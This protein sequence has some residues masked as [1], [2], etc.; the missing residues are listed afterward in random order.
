[1]T[2]TEPEPTIYVDPDGV[3]YHQ[4]PDRMELWLPPES[5]APFWHLV[6]SYDKREDDA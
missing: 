2:T 5:D 6:T 3:E 4:Y 1:M